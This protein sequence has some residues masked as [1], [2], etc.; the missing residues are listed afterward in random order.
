MYTLEAQDIRKS[1]GGVHAL[2]GVGLAVRP[3]SV[4]A[5]LGENG[6][7]KST[8]VKIMTGATRPDSGI[9]RLD[10]REVRF[11]STAGASAAGVSVV[12]QE[13]SLFPHLSVLANLFPMRE[14]RWGP[15][16]D[17]RTMLRRA[18]PILEQL[19]VSVAPTTLVEELALSERQ[20]VEIAKALVS[21]PRVLLLDEPTSAL[22]RGATERLL[23]ILRVL[24]ER[25]V[26]VVFVSHLLEEVMSVCDE[27][28]VLRDGAVAAGGES[29]SEH[30]VSSLVKA[31]IGDKVIEHPEARAEAAVELTTPAGAGLRMSGIG[32]DRRLTDVTLTARP[33]EVIGLVGLAG[34]G[35]TQLLRVLAGIDA[36]TTG[37]LTLPDGAPAPRGQRRHVARGVAYVSGDRRRLGLML[38]KPIWEN[39]VQVR[40]MAMGRDGWILRQ[41]TL[42]KRA[43]DH[44]VRLQIKAPSSGSSAGS[45]SGGNQQKV[46]LAKW[47]DNTPS[48]I[49][50]D[51][52]TR[53]VDVGAR[54]EIHALLQG[55]AK[56]GA[57]VLLYST[58]LQELSATCDRI[59]VFY[60]GRIC[61]ELAGEQ[62][63][64]RVMLEVM[65]TGV[66]PKRSAT[67]QSR[68]T[69]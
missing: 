30:S 22:E 66:A 55:S 23:G 29:I 58:D 61:A 31:M 69:T 33:G 26:A 6:A 16:V 53:G 2:T 38:D 27:V 18:I 39:I 20:L 65:N 46:V 48:T 54:A 49:L 28:T 64:S 42:K 15:F 41:S 4:H 5:L 1:Y 59:L 13:L 51:D 52:P 34:A 62:M 24:R 36:P 50:L 68:G 40:S 37:T 11:E 3:G 60:Q 25:Q 9:L 21:E 19:G 12:A 57:V 8:L 7:G 63:T 44:M 56:A 32:F 43:N 47:L 14:P 67:P 35:P 45:L 10:G 17:R